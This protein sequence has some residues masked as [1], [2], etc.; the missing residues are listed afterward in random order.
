M[1]ISGLAFHCHHD[2]LCEYV[3][4]FDERVR[5]IKTRKPPEERELRLRLFKMIP[6]ELMPGRESML[7][8]DYRKARADYCKARADYCK[9]WADYD[10]ACADYCKAQADYISKFNKEIKQLHKELCPDCPWNGKTIF[11]E[12]GVK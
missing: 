7:W 5:Y 6:T 9:A 11:T 12:G 3:Y 10:K 4:D 1:K 2:I 8:A